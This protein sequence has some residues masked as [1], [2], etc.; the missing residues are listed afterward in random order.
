[1][2][3]VYTIPRCVEIK[4]RLFTHYQGVPVFLVNVQ[5]RPSPVMFFH[6]IEKEIIGISMAQFKLSTWPVANGHVLTRSNQYALGD[7][8]CLALI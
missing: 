2:L 8:V 7:L 4:Q 6:V 5:P 3:G 1:M